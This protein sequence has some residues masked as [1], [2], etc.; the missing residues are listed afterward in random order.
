MMLCLVKALGVKETVQASSDCTL[1]EGARQ[2]QASNPGVA[3]GG[4]ARARRRKK[5]TE[6]PAWGVVVLSCRF[7]LNAVSC[8][9][10]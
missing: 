8:V 3:E 10:Q 9:R 6:N 2:G 7:R 4:R 1:G 5:T